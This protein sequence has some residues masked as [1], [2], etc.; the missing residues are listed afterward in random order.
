[1]RI[2]Q[3][4][5]G[6]WVACI[7]G[8]T[9][10]DHEELTRLIPAVVIDEKSADYH[11][12]VNAYMRRRGWRIAYVGPDVPEGYAIATGLAAR[13]H[14]HA[15]IVKDGKL[16]HDPHESRAG[17]ISTEGYEVVIPI[18]D[19]RTIEVFPVRHR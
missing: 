11:N 12:A 17:L 10:L 18:I 5:N 4:P 13:G 16:W 3:A 1:M 14:Q 8:L 6:C 15:V 19:S 2:D 9:G 7:A